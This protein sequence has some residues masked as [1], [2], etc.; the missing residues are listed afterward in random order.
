MVHFLVG[1]MDVLAYFLKLFLVRTTTLTIQLIL[2]L[3]K[4]MTLTL[5]QLNAGVLLILV[6]NRR[7]HLVV[8]SRV[9]VLAALASML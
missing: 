4:R 7:P 2:D 9:L 1:R 3:L 5:V 6:Q 8:K